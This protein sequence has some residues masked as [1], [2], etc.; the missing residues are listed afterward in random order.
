MK[1][2][3]YSSYSAWSKVFM[4][5]RVERDITSL[6]LAT[7]PLK[8]RSWMSGELSM[9]SIAAIRP[10]PASRATTRCAVRRGASRV[11]V[12]VV[13]RLLDGDGVRARVVVAIADHGGECRRLSRAGAADDDH[14]PALAEHHFLQDR[15][16]VELLEGGDLGVDQADHAADR[17]LLHERADAEDADPAG[18]SRQVACLGCV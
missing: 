18:D 7:S 2:V 5:R 12:R 8:I 4:P 14:P 11:G 3:S 13:D 1:P 10:E 15:R 9:I 16:Q 17:R 6:I